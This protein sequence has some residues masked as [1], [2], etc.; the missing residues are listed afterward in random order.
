MGVMFY[1]SGNTFQGEFRNS[2]RVYGVY[3]FANGNKELCKYDD[4][5]NEIKSETIKGLDV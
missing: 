1:A 2:I 3:T 4:A 5:G